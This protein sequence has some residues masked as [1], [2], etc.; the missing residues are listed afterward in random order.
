[1]LSEWDRQAHSNGLRTQSNYSL[2]TLLHQFAPQCLDGGIVSFQR[3]PR[4]PLFL[5][6]HYR[7]YRRHR[8]ET[9]NI[10]VDVVWISKT[11]ISIVMVEITIGIGILR[12]KHRVICFGI[13]ASAPCFGDRRVMMQ[14]QRQGQRRK[15][16]ECL[17]C[18]LTSAAQDARAQLS[19]EEGSH[20]RRL[21][22]VLMQLPGKLSFIH[23]PLPPH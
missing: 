14:E 23:I 5:R 3:L 12:R 4:P 13:G 2:D 1:M 7:Y 20:D 11:I 21:L 6:L 19:L 22:R 10:E 16:I 17:R 8:P 15:D 9:E 18:M